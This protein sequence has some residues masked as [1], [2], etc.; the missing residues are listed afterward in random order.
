MR[1]VAESKFLKWFYSL[2]AVLFVTLLLV[3]RCAGTLPGSPSPQNPPSEAQSSADPPSNKPTEGRIGYL[4][5]DS[6]PSFPLRSI[7]PSAGGPGDAVQDYDSSDGSRV[8]VL[9][10][11][12]DEPVET[13][14]RSTPVRIHGY[15]GVRVVSQGYVFIGWRVNR[16]LFALWAYPPEGTS[17][18]SS[19]RAMRA[20]E[21]VVQYAERRMLS[22]GGILL[23]P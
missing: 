5:P 20:A 2:S 1:E 16:Y 17:Q 22:D 9:V 23:P 13:S 19:S 12:S 10:R 14:E 7:R 4:L 21:Q 8:H 11:A 15:R 18:V 6:I 3:A